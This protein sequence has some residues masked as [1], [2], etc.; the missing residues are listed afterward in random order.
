MNLSLISASNPNRRIVLTATCG[1][2]V[3]NYRKEVVLYLLE[4]GYEVH[5]IAG[6]DKFLQSLKEM[7][8][9]IHA[10]KITNRGKNLIHD[11]QLFFS[12]L[13][14]YRKIRPALIFHYFIKTNIYGSI[15]ASVLKIPSIA[16]VAGLGYSFSK[17]NWL[18]YCVLKL[19]RLSLRSNYKVWFQNSEDAEYFLREKIVSKEQLTIIPGDGIC[20]NTFKPVYNKMTVAKPFTFIMAVRL[21]KSKG[22]NYYVKAAKMLQEKGYE[23]EC[24]LIGPFDINHPDSISMN[25]LQEWQNND[26]IHYCGFTENIKAYLASCDCL[27]LPTYYPEGTPR[28]LMEACSM[29]LPVIATD[30][31]GCRDIIQDGFNGYLCTPKDGLELFHKME[32]MLLLQ[33]SERMAMGTNGRNKMIEE[34]DIKKLLIIYQSAIDSFINESQVEKIQTA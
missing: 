3:I 9:F 11:C 17:N 18:Q 24:Q 23:V 8:C 33:P 26:P 12:L 30:I 27:V 7:G 32:K 1:W 21:L 4:Q 34:Y 13:N 6:E 29:G 15:A 10:I 25:Q 14:M 2:S 28:S 31:K 19:Y 5:I 20:T 16:V 22:I